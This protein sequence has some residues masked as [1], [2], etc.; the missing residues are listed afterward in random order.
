MPMPGCELT[1]ELLNEQEVDKAKSVSSSII[2]NVE[3]V[4]IGK[5]QAIELAVIT[6]MSQGHLL[7]EDSPGVGKTIF[8][9]SLAV[10]LGCS[11]KRIQFTADLLPSDITGASI[12]NQKNSEFEFRPG[13]VLAQMVLADE[14][15]RA[16][17]KVQSALLE[18]MGE[19]QITVD[20]ATHLMPT[21]FH[22]LATQNPMEYEGTFPL[23]ENQLDRFLVRLTLGYPSDENEI[24]IMTSQQFEHP[25][26][27]LSSVA[28]PE[29]LLW[30]QSVVK[31]VFV[32]EQVKKYIVSVVA[33][34]RHNPEIA[35]GISPRGSLGLFRTA[36]SRAILHGRDYVIPDDIKALGEAVLAH[37]LVMRTGGSTEFG[38]GQ[39]VIARILNSVPVPGARSSF[40][41]NRA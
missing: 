22:V 6:L 34:T 16:T 30:L 23:P 29:D 31:R 9:R 17:P 38:S 2:D 13:P 35:T 41:G 18:C 37:R 12:F 10:S 32:G 3:N 8:A 36:Q 40:H 11:F 21:P 19:H 1:G 27:C 39:A 5:R 14:I 7:I 26:H 20:G 25:I 24:T 15:N 33:A 4:I 28:G